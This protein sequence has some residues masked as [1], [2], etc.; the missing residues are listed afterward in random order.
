MPLWWPWDCSLQTSPTGRLCADATLPI[1]SQR[2]AGQGYSG[3]HVPGR[4]GTPLTAD[5]GLETPWQLWR[6]LLG[7]HGGLGCSHPT[8]LLSFT[9]GWTHIAIDGSPSLFGPCF[10]QQILAYLI[11]CWSLILKGLGLTQALRIALGPLVVRRLPNPKHHPI[12]NPMPSLTEPPSNFACQS[13]NQLKSGNP[14][15]KAEV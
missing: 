4:P 15:G 5:F 3:R 8:F 11:S 12:L 9:Q 1:P 14:N 6:I 7:L 13:Q 10:P 2:L